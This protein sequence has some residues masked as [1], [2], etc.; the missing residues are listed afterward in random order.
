MH[1]ADAI[2]EAANDGISLIV[3]ITEGIPVSDMITVK[4]ISN[5]IIPG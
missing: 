2:M 5:H 1:A 4:N 3:A